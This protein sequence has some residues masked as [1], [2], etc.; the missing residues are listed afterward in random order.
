V[1]AAGARRDTGILG[2]RT[3]GDA[4]DNRKDEEERDSLHAVV[5]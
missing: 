4:A 5:A 1:R 3:A 2:R